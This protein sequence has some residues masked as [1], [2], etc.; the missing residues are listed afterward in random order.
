MRS[1]HRHS[2]RMQN[3]ILARPKSLLPRANHLRKGSYVR[4][5]KLRAT[6]GGAP[7]CPRPIYEPGLWS[8]FLSLPVAYWMEGVLLADMVKRST[9]RLH[10]CVRDGVVASGVFT[11]TPICD[12]SDGE[13][14][15]YNSIYLVELVTPF[16]PG[17]CS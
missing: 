6:P 10:R 11:S 16:I 1:S 13:V 5:T 15:T 2:R 7:A 3:R 8:E 12:I 14:T 9:I 17:L 4:I